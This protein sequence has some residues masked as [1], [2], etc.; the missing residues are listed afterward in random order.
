MRRFVLA[1][2]LVFL[3]TA[4]AAQTPPAQTTAPSKE[5][6]VRQLLVIMRTGDIGVQIV[7]QMIDAFKENM[8][9]APEAFWTG[10]RAKVKP[11]ELIEMLVPLYMK[12]L[13]TSDVD[14]LIRFY[15]SPAGQHFLDKQPVMMKESMAVGQEW[16][17]RLAREA[18]EEL[19]KNKS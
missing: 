18:Y 5:E 19:Q 13:E 11:N 6:K 2:L 7:D 8:P 4:A 9:D 1:A 16:G 14:E 10:F 3:A 17:Q 15:S 12:H